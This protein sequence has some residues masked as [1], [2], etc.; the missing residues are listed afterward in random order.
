[1]IELVPFDRLGRFENAWLDARYHFSFASYRDP[2]RM[3]I[4]PLPSGTTTA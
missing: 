4:G 2:Q 3:G 1:M